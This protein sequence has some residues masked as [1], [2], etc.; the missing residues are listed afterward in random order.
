MKVSHHQPAL[1][2]KVSPSISLPPCGPLFSGCGRAS[3]PNERPSAG[4]VKARPGA[5]RPGR[6]TATS[7]SVLVPAR[8]GASE[9]S[10]FFAYSSSLP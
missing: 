1:L 6:N 4:W 2:V 10:E 9:G 3:I 5:E 7:G 8:A